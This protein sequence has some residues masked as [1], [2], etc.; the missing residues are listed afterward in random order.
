VAEPALQASTPVASEE[1]LTEQEVLEKNEEDRKKQPFTGFTESAEQRVERMQ[2]RS[3]LLGR[4]NEE[5]KDP[6]WTARESSLIAGLL[7]N[8]EFSRDHL[9]EIDCRE[10][11]CRFQLQTSNNTYGEV[12]SLIGVAHEL[13]DETWLRAEPQAKEPQSHIEIFVPRDGYRLSGGGGR[14]DAPPTIVHDYEEPPEA[15][16]PEQG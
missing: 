9:K 6:S 7:A 8:A 15:A 1:E 16:T 12:M 4:W 13:G 10:T 5:A 11:I 3:E 2:E 14:I